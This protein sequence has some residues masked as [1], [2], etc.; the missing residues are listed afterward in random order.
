MDSRYTVVQ[1]EDSG[2]ALNDLV[3][4]TSVRKRAGDDLVNA[5]RKALQSPSL[6]RNA[7][8]ATTYALLPAEVFDV[9]HA[10]E[11]DNQLLPTKTSTEAKPRDL[12]PPVDIGSSTRFQCFVALFLGIASFLACTIYGIAL[13]FTSPGSPLIQLPEGLPGEAIS[14]IVTLILTQCLEGLAYVHSISLRWALLRE[15]RLVFN[16]NIRLFTS[17][18]LSRPNSRYINAIS[19]TLLIL[20]YGATSLLVVPQVGST[21]GTYSGTYINLVALLSL[22]VALFG[23]TLL[24]IWCYYNN[25]RNIPS[26]SSNPLNTTVNMLKQQFIQHREGRCINSVQRKDLSEERSMLPRTR[27]PSPWQVNTTARHVTIFTWILVGLSFVW[28]LTIVLVSRS[29][30]IGT[31]NTI[32]AMSDGH[33]P[34]DLTWHFSLAWSFAIVPNVSSISTTSYFNAV[35][36]SL[37]LSEQIGTGPSLSFVGTVIVS[38]VFVCVIQGLQTL[39]L[40]GAELVVNLSRDE[41]VWR[42]LDAQGRS[43]RKSHVLSTPSSLAALMSWK[44]DILLIFKSLLHWLLGQSIRPCLNLYGIFYF[45][46]NYARLFVYA[47]CA[48]I[49]ASTITILAIMKPKGPQPATYGHIQTI[50]DVIDDWTLDGKGQFWWGDKGCREGVR[51]AGMSSRRG[52]LGPIRM[53]APYAGEVSKRFTDGAKLSTNC[54]DWEQS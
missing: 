16:T 29:N 4:N 13:R 17:S 3:A 1:G 22:G 33:P 36:F 40:H 30:T 46:M 18:R 11:E 34:V 5:S 37:D 45:S 54:E 6:R 28:F 42:A 20:C 10:I 51:H 41:D 24:A 49:F 21:E 43:H 7:R 38:L 39:G 52:D 32:S 27:Q 26:W 2:P 25:L 12:L 8:D 15:N 23:Q 35:F 44:Y 14:F 9:S 47:I 53:N 48:T 50:A 19:A 31:I